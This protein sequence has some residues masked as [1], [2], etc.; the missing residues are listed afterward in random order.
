MVLTS[1]QRCH[2]TLSLTHTHCLSLDAVSVNDMRVYQV[3]NIAVAGSLHHGKT[4]IMDM[5]VQQTHDKRWHISKRYGALGPRIR[6]LGSGRGV[7]VVY[8]KFCVE[9]VLLRQVS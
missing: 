7:C 1:K 3:R 8:P 4:S 9:L 6:S 5:F 2:T